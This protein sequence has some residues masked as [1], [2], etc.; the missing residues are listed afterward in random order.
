MN[1]KRLLALF[2]VIGVLWLTAMWWATGFIVS[3]EPAL[4]PASIKADSNLALNSLLKTER[5]ELPLCI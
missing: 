5:L 2:L 4:T 3:I 1:A